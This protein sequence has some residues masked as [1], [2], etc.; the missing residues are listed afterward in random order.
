MQLLGIDTSNWDKV[1]AFCGIVV[2]QVRRFRELDC[3]ELDVLQVK[4]RAICRKKKNNNN[5]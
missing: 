1:N 4:L 5:H 2:S 3:E